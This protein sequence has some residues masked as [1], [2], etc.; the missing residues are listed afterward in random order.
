MATKTKPFDCVDMKRNIQQGL[1]REFQSRGD[2][3]ASY[4]EFLQDSIAK[5]E[6]SRKQ[7]ERLQPPEGGS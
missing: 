2:A 1:L 4:A 7:L 3:F 5:N 6:W